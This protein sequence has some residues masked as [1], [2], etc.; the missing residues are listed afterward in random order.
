MNSANLLIYNLSF[1]FGFCPSWLVFI[2]Y[3]RQNRAIDRSSLW[4]DPFL[5]PALLRLSFRR[6]TTS[7]VSGR[8]VKWSV[9]AC[10]LGTL[11]RWVCIFYT[12]LSTEW[13]DVNITD[14]FLFKENMDMYSRVKRRK[15]LRRNNFSLPTHHKVMSKSEQE[16]EEEEGTEGQFSHN[17]SFCF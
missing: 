5:C 6:W 1:C 10:G 9:F 13:P 8:T 3:M 4:L 12:V 2:F 17:A 16:E 11:K 7:A 15:S 14:F